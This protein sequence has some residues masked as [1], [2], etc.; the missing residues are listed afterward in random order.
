MSTIFEQIISGQIPCY[1]VTENADFF[2]FL[3]IHPRS[4]GHT[5]VIPKNSYRW[6][7]DVPN[8]GD[9]LEF[10]KKISIAIQL[11]LKPDLVSL[12]T[13]GTDVPH[14]HVHLI[15][16]YSSDTEHTQKDIFLSSKEFQ[17]IASSISKM[18]K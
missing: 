6:V 1:K 16:K 10:C 8:F 14:A 2:A 11:A 3:D 4:P 9:Y 12:Y 5:L 7:W 15:P 17:Q 13:Y 18:L